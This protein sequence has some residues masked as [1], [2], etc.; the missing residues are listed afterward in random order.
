[1]S[2]IDLEQP[3]QWRLEVYNPQK[4]H[5]W[6]PLIEIAEG[7]VEAAVELRNEMNKTNFPVLLRIVPNSD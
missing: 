4:S 6:R 1:M 5:E 7:Q 3:N 2:R